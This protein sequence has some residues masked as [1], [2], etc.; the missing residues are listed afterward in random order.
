[1]SPTGVSLEAIDLCKILSKLTSEA[2]NEYLVGV[3]MGV[4]AEAYVH[5][6]SQFDEHEIPLLKCENDM[7]HS[8]R[9][10]LGERCRRV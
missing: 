1:M 9:G 2:Q 7:A 5:Q 8:I 4:L 10:L 6:L 3:Q